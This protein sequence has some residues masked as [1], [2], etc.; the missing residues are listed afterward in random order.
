LEQK[1]YKNEQK[2]VGDTRLVTSNA[3]LPAEPFRSKKAPTITTTTT[4]TPTT[5]S[6]SFTKGMVLVWNVGN[7]SANKKVEWVRSHLPLVNPL[8]LSLSLSPSLK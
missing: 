3:M 5:A 2:R 6:S 1:V 8:S 4:P 7:W